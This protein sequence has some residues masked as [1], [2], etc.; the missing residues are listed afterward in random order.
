MTNPDKQY[1]STIFFIGVKSKDVALR[2]LFPHNNVR[3][4]C[5]DGVVNLRLDSSTMSS[6]YPLL[7]AD[8]DPQKQIPDKLGTMRCHENTTVPLI[9]RS[10]TQ[11]NNIQ[12]LYARLVALFSDVVC[13]FAEDLGGLRGTARFLVDWVKFGNPSS[14]PRCVRP[15]VMIVTREEET[16]ITHHVLE[17]EELRFMLD[18][19]DPGLRSQVFSSISLIHLPGDHISALARYRRLREILLKEVDL[20]RIQRLEQRVLFSA[21]HLEAFSSRAFKNLA[22]SFDKPFDFI[23]ESRVGNEL[24]GTYNDHITTFATGCNENFLSFKS[25]SSFIASSILMDAY[26]PRMHGKILL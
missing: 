15:R 3:R 13:I 22:L 11:L 20:S 12:C 21:V 4:G 7:F 19:E 9:S 17:M 14:L 1:P 10:F 6:E 24:D 5:L 16:A 8:G 2:Q 18:Q 25:L 26:P 23:I